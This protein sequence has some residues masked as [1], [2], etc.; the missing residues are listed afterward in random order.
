M[1]MTFSGP[2]AEDQVARARLRAAQ[3]LQAGRP[4]RTTMHFDHTADKNGKKPSAA[5][6]AKFA[7]GSTK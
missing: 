1:A 3:P 4:T 5:A 7:I 6:N 2:Y